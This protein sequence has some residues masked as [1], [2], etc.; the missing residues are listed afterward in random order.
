[1][2]ISDG[3]ADF[4]SSDLRRRRPPVGGFGDESAG[5][6][7]R[8]RRAV[9]ARPLVRQR[10]R[11]AAALL[12]AA[13]A[14]ARCD[15]RSGGLAARAAR[16]LR[17]RGAP[18]ADER[19]ALRRARSEEHTSELQPLMRISYAVFCFKKKKQQTNTQ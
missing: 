1:M 10:H 14:R 7:V 2:R 4:C 17:A 15:A 8:R 13:M 16:G 9:P 19:R 3:I 11:T 18:S 6:I 12:P 5:A